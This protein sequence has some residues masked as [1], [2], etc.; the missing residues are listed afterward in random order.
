MCYPRSFYPNV[1]IVDLDHDERH[2]NCSQNVKK[3]FQTQKTICYYKNINHVQLAAAQNEA[4]DVNGH[5][6]TCL[7]KE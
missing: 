5:H 6:L 3:Q 2:S 4:N 7:N 1:E